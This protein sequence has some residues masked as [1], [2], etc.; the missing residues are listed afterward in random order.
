MIFPFDSKF[1][2]FFLFIGICVCMCISISF[3]F[4]LLGFIHII[5]NLTVRPLDNYSFAIN[6]KT[7]FSKM[8]IKVVVFLGIISLFSLRLFRRGYY[9]DWMSYKEYIE[10]IYYSRKEIPLVICLYLL[11]LTIL[12]IVIVRMLMTLCTYR[13]K[14]LFM[15]IH[16]YLLQFEYYNVSI[17]YYLSNLNSS[18]FGC[19]VQKRTNFYVCIFI[20]RYSLFLEK[21]IYRFLL[22]YLYIFDIITN[23]G[24]ISSILCLTLLLLIWYNENIFNNFV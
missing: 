19:F 9:I 13:I 7:D 2:C 20:Y 11:T 18:Y 17:R 6:N 5:Y 10:I 4:I 23:F 3:I 12:L 22:P 21:L 15:T 14:E 8:I 16:V 24:V 1:W